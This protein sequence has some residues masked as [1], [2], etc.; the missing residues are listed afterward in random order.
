[1]WCV[2]WCVC[3]IMFNICNAEFVL[4]YKY[5][6]TLYHNYLNL[7]QN[8]AFSVLTNFLLVPTYLKAFYSPL[9]VLI[10]QSF[11]K[12]LYLI[13]YP[14]STLQQS[15]PIPVIVL[16]PPL[17]LFMVVRPHFHF[18]SF[19]LPIFT[20]SYRS[21]RSFAQPSRFFSRYCF[22]SSVTLFSTSLLPLLLL[23]HL[24]NI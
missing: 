7:Y 13:S 16:S 18:L 17:L 3:L 4:L 15:L 19:L 12:Q 1:M 10:I 23:V 5:Y 22:L 24:S 9:S 8:I 2:C 20:S 11:F 6:S 21:L 14:R